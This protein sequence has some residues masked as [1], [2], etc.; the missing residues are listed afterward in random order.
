MA[1]PVF[2]SECESVNSISSALVQC[3]AY[4]AV[5]LAGLGQEVEQGG[6]GACDVGHGAVAAA[7]CAVVEVLA[8]VG[9]APAQE[10]SRGG[11][12]PLAGRLGAT[13]GGITVALNLK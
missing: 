1:V 3:L 8:D 11:R 12:L 13:E 4:G 7:G 5:Q 6:H 2:V 9:S 10:A